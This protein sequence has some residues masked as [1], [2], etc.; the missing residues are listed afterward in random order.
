[1][2]LLKLRFG[3][4][5]MHYCEVM[6]KVMSQKFCHIFKIHSQFGA[7]LHEVFVPVRTWR[8]HGGSTPTS[9]RRSRS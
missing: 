5:H 6:L 7:A 3:E 8:T 9:A 2:E 4:S 1:M